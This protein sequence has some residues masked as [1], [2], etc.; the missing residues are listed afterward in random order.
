MVVDEDPTADTIV[1]TERCLST[2]NVKMEIDK[3]VKRRSSTQSRS[4][5]SNENPTVNI[6]GLEV[7]GENDKIQWGF[8]CQTSPD[9]E[10]K[11]QKVSHLSVKIVNIVFGIVK[12][13]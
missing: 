1:D 10:T 8:D 11:L 2:E 13:S 9:F 7:A 12:V 5:S 3:H 6:M 4:S